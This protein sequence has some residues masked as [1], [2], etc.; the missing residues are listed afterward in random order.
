MSKAFTNVRS[1]M[2][3]LAKSM[4]LVNPDM[5]HQFRLSTRNIVSI[6]TYFL[7]T[8]LGGLCP[9]AAFIIVAVVSAWWIFP[10]KK[11]A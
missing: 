4:N 8:V 5:E 9:T 1:L 6:L 11:G 10:E 2:G 3:V 7:A